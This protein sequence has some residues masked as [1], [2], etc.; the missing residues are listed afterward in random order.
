MKKINTTSLLAS[1]AILFFA[2]SVS[3]QL[4]GGSVFLKGNYV[5]AGICA[6]GDFG[7]ASPPAGYH[8]HTTSAGGGALGFVA[9]PA[10]DG[11][12]VGTPP[13]TGDFFTPG[14]PF[15]GW[16]LQIG[17]IRAQAQSCMG[18][19][20]TGGLTGTNT[21]YAISG[22]KKIATWQG[23]FDSIDIK[24]ETTLDTTALFFSLR[25]TLTNTASV[26]KNDIYY[27]R[28]LDPDND[29][30]WPGGGFNTINK[31]EYQ[32][33]NPSNSTV[34]SARG[35][36]DPT[37]YL[38]LGTTDSFAK[39]LVYTSWPISSTVDL[40]TLYS[41][42]YTGGG[43]YYTLGHTD[44]AD[45][46]IGVVFYVN[47]LAPADSSSDSVSNKTT[48]QAAIHRHPAN[49]KTFTYYYAFRPDAVDSAIKQLVDTMIHTPDTTTTTTGISNINEGKSVNVYPNPSG[50]VI[51][52][53]NLDVADQVIL[54]DMMGKATPQNW[55]INNQPVNTFSLR[56][57]PTGSYILLIQDAG[58]NMKA[59]V[60][61]RKM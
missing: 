31:I 47:H 14:S 25:I 51:N 54:I 29:E 39:C 6:N 38:A 52:I 61:V 58:G 41:G 7:A 24:Q 20:G 59:R 9:D 13:Y 12:T 26:A 19:A 37:S 53:T 42:T 5:E 48:N 56:N 32:L 23:S 33:P 18:F 50:D 8:P 57:V 60:P 36:G 10:M 45:L 27:L 30:S 4:V 17:S 44:S 2:G 34:V 35:L 11:W 55:I 22:S 49:Q 46:A 28:S 3:A 15:E 43:A 40:S 21:A 1:I 16:N